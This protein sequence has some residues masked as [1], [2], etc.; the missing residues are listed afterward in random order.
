MQPSPNLAGAAAAAVVGSSAVLKAKEA[1]ASAVAELD[2]VVV[3]LH[4]VVAMGEDVKVS[5][6]QAAA[7]GAKDSCQERQTAFRMEENIVR[8]IEMYAREAQTAVAAVKVAVDSWEKVVRQSSLPPGLS[9]VRRK[10]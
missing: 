8:T 10:Q 1:A 3:M 6:E 5:E 9:R 4:R 7:Q 2:Q